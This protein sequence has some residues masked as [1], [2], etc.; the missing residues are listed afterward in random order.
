M[1]LWEDG[2]ARKLDTR[3]EPGHVAGDDPEPEGEARD[4][5]ILAAA[6]AGDR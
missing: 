1:L 6:Q 2:V 5:T 4:P 3:N